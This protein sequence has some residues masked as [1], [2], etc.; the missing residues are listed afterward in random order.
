MNR[1][2]INWVRRFIVFVD[3]MYESHVKLIVQAE[4]EPDGIFTVDLEDASCDEVFAFDRTRSR[5][6]EMR[7]QQYL[8]KRWAGAAGQGGSKSNKEEDDESTEEAE[9]MTA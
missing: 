2:Q 8:K 4:T 5:L 9:Q 3:S 1:N 6:E 7:S